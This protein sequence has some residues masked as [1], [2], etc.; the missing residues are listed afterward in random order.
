MIDWSPITTAL[1]T[2]IAALITTLVP[3]FV[4]YIFKAVSTRLLVVKQITDK[5]QTLAHDVV[6]WVEATMKTASSNAKLQA[7][8]AKFNETL[9]LPTDTIVNLLETAISAAKFEAAD[10]WAKLGTPTVPDQPIQQ[11]TPTD[12]DTLPLA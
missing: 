7:A 9:N 8:I 3:V 4:D 10:D 1:V 5:N 2:L 6:V 12:P 11:E